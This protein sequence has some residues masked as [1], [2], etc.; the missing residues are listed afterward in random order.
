MMKLT[1]P[2]VTSVTPSTG[3][4]GVERAAQNNVSANINWREKDRQTSE[5]GE[6]RGGMVV[7]VTCRERFREELVKFVQNE[8]RHTTPLSNTSSVIARSKC[9]S[10]ENIYYHDIIK[11]AEEHQTYDSV[12][13][14]RL[15]GELECDVRGS[16]FPKHSKFSWVLKKLVTFAE[17]YYFAKTCREIGLRC[18]SSEE[19]EYSIR[20]LRHHDGELISDQALGKVELRRNERVRECGA[21]WGRFRGNGRVIR[22][23]VP[24]KREFGRTCDLATGFAAAD[25]TGLDWM[26]K[27]MTPRESSS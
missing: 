13:I 24:G 19:E 10:P 27:S 9:E 21:V 17:T 11:L 7:K 6:G 25:A 2:L 20:V 8:D 16:R 3:G 4:T 1:G 26:M 22:D 12:R 15:L 14:M 5:F 18:G 23:F